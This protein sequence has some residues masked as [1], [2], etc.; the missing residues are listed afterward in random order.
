MGFA[1]ADRVRATVLRDSI[2]L[3]R[4]TPVASAFQT[5]AYSDVSGLAVQV[6]ANS[7]YALD[8]DLVWQSATAADIQFSLM[9]PT[10]AIGHWAC[11]GPTQ[12]GGA[13]GDIEPFR[14]EG[15]NEAR[16]SDFWRQGQAGAGTTTPI[17]APLR[18]QVDT[19]PN[20]G[21]IQVRFA[22]INITASQTVVLAGS[23]LRATKIG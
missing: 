15:I 2:T 14:N 19:G 1:V 5:D 18:G 12:T 3:V 17:C 13:V 23:W 10:G 11:M 16:D 20:D 22:Q 8:G 6:L 21:A 9:A 4:H 7:V